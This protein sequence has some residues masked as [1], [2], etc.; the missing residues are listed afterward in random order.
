MP[1]TCAW[2]AEQSA[3]RAVMM[4]YTLFIDDGSVYKVNELTGGFVANLS[5]RM[6][7]GLFHN[8]DSLHRTVFHLLAHDVQA[9]LHFIQA[10]T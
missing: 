9:V 4:M 6:M 5:T 8:L 1:L 3:I 7:N 2:L 10:H